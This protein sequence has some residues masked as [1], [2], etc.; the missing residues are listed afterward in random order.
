MPVNGAAEEHTTR[1]DD[2]FQWSLNPGVPV[3]RALVAAAQRLDRAGSESA[4]LDAQ[5]LLGHVLARGRSWLFAH[6]D[7]ELSQADCS[8]FADLITRRRQREPVAYLLGRKEFYGLEFAVDR[9]VLIPRPETELLVDLALAQINACPRGQAVVA[10][11]GAGSGA[12]AITIALRAPSAKVYAID[13]SRDALDVAEENRRRLIPDGG[14][15]LLEGDLLEPL[16]EAADVIVANLPYIADEEYTRLQSDV[17]DYE[18]RLALQAGAQ[19][20]DL[21]ERLLGPTRRQGALERQRAARNLPQAG[22]SRPE[23]GAR[24]AAETRLCRPEAR[25]QRTHAHGDARILNAAAARINRGGAPETSLH[26][27]RRAAMQRPFDLAV[28]DMDGTIYGRRFPGGVSPRVR[29]AIAAVQAAGTPVTLATGRVFAFVRVIAR[30]LGLALPVITAQGAQI[31]DPVSGEILH[32]ALIPQAAARAAAVWADAQDRTTVFYLAAPDGR[33]RLAQNA[34]R[35]VDGAAGREGW[36][37]GVYD[38]WFGKPREI[39]A[40]LGELLRSSPARA[41][42]F[43]TV[44]DHLREA[45]LSPALQKRFGGDILISRSHRLLVEG[46]ALSANKGR[47]LALLAA[48]LGIDPARVIAIGDNENDIPMLR[49]AGLAVCMGQAPPIVQAEA[50][51][52]APPFDEDGAA[53][54]L[55]RFILD[56]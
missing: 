27:S 34:F 29:R 37:S 52:V 13:I 43:I 53:A 40:G 31:G 47:A 3:G 36:E 2:Q 23:N 25:L 56:A 10:D 21:I 35:A 38:H 51:W 5:V 1:A 30:E 41:L 39:H 17:R 11:V 19:G 26:D 16:P 49:A 54:A 44:N 8:R 32:E 20:L 28:L 42:K 45:D 50:D 48:R 24:A 33:A 22:R 4:M 9:R 18:P 6:Y 15:L 12:I 46:T 14:P 7:H 55:E